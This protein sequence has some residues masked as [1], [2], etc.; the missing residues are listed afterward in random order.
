MRSALRSLLVIAFVVV[1]VFTLGWAAPLAT[2]V[3]LLATTA[4]IMG[5]TQH[6]LV[7][8]SNRLPDVDGQASYGFSEP[9]LA[10]DD[11]LPAGYVAAALNTYVRTAGPADEQYNV[12]AVW[13]PEA[14]WP[15]YG[16]QT[17]DASVRTGLDNLDV[18]VHGSQCIAHVYAGGETGPA[19]GY[20][21]F[22]YSQSARIASLQKA[23]LIAEYDPADDA[24]IHHVTFVLIGNPNRGNGGILQRFEG[25]H[26]PV[27][28]VSFDGAS[29]TNSPVVD[30]DFLYPTADIARQYDGWTDF[31][32]YPLNLLAVLN[33][34]AGIMYLHG[35][36][37]VGDA[38]NP[39]AGQRYLYQGQVGDTNYYMIA[40]NRLPLLLPL[41]SLGV[42]EPVLVALDAPLR[43]MVEWGYKRDVS[44]GVPTTARLFRPVDP[45]TDIG[46]LVVATLTGL[47]DAASLASGD[48][49]D[50]PF[51]TKP[52]DSTF[53]V[54]GVELPTSTH[55]VAPTSPAIQSS[56]V[57]SSAVERKGASDNT[58]RVV[59][60]DTA[61]LTS[62]P[63]SGAPLGGPPKPQPADDEKAQAPEVPAPV[64]ARGDGS[65]AGVGAVPADTGAAAGEEAP[66]V[67][68][69]TK[70]RLQLAARSGRH[71]ATE[72]A[73][74]SERVR[75]KAVERGESAWR[76]V[77][78]RAHR[79]AGGDPKSVGGKHRSLPSAD[80][81][82]DSAE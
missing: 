15:V 11:G 7:D 48:P 74:Q 41:A 24:T 64:P 37:F 47:D 82:S 77:G 49:D 32:A 79:A 42:P 70:T 80:S 10:D 23:S 60:A 25:L 72:S 36:Y 39:V 27:L 51:G 13:T 55:P 75:E 12:V 1:G 22:A 73:R 53:G 44:P 45:V 19:D 3:Q 57:E 50:R 14:F 62:A 43:V 38:A 4:L 18:C 58:A 31:P 46:H 35:D 56:V 29:P 21:V 6:P 16:A 81:G 8:P 59:G 76:T 33:A 61:V 5:G 30:G 63:V 20:A 68:K 2:V 69:P 34:A 66:D 65:A 28:D 78:A 40:T 9:G 17:F 52:V 26:I 71:W 54:G 67:E